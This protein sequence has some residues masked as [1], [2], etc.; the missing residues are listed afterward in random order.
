MIV[1]CSLI[2]FIFKY[3]DIFVH[4]YKRLDENDDF[5]NKNVKIK[6]KMSKNKI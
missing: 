3:E 2:F 5:Y 1:I 6:V 4:L